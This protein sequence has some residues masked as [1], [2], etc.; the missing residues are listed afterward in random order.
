VGDVDQVVVAADDVL[1]EVDRDLVEP[2][3][4]PVE[5]DLTVV[6]TVDVELFVPAGQRRDRQTG[7][8]PVAGAGL[9]PAHAVQDGCQGSPVVQPDEDPGGW[10]VEIVTVG[11]SEVCWRPGSAR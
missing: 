8:Q 2:W 6:P 11:I 4:H 1:Q 7:G 10:R 9:A 5:D 3:V